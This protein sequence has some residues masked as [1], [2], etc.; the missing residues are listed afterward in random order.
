MAAVALAA[1]GFSFPFPRIFDRTVMAALVAALLIF[2]SRLKLIDRLR[3][4][5][6]DIRSGI[7]Q[8]VKGAALAGAATAVL[9]AL[10]AFAG[11]SI[12]WQRILSATVHYLPSAVLIASL[13]ESFFRVFLLAGIEGEFGSSAALLA[14]SV[15]Y[16]IVHVIRSPARFYVTTM[17]PMA[18]AETLA[19]YA[20]RLI[21]PEIAPSLFGLFLLGI[22]LGEAFVLTRRAY[23]PIGLHMGFVL[24]AKSW[25]LA[26]AGNIPQWLAGAGSVPLIAAPAAWAVS[27]ITMVVLPILL[28]GVPKARLAPAPRDSA[29]R[30]NQA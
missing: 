2:A 30:S 18:G 3:R 4:G 17:Q 23:W 15:V 16:A 11:G 27:V 10:A 24:G 28:R 19:A 25:R 12:S 5:F 29:N 14:S 21:H 7:P 8:A 22:V 26:V 9:F 1:E 20:R 13:E 6:T